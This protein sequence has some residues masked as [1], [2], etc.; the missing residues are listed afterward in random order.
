[1]TQLRWRAERSAAPRRPRKGRL[2]L[3]AA[4]ALVFVLLLVLGTWQVQR[5]AWKTDL[6]ARVESRLAAPPVPSP[7]PADWPRM[8]AAADEYRRVRLEGTFLPEHQ[9]LTQAL[10][11]RGAGFWVLTPLRAGDGTTLLVN[12][13]FVPTERRDPLSGRA[14]GVEPPAG[15]VTVIGLLRLSEPGGGFLRGNDP[16]GNRWYSRDVAAI[17][18]A[19]GLEEV[20]PYFVDADAAGVPGAG[21]D[22]PVGGLT[23]VAFRNHHLVYALTWYTLA[24]M[25]AGAG[26]WL[27][28]DARRRERGD[29]G[30]PAERVP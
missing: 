12:R 10:T 3:A 21:P 18:R 19:Q 27:R 8:N 24:A 14:L 5:I 13:G 17:A 7:G 1:M 6:V 22:A 29:A 9:V 30:S 26:L 25:L 16:A 20:A 11:E 15:P 28:R 4:G 2:A 23:V